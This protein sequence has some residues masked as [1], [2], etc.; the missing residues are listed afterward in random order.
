MTR[1]ESGRLK[2]CSADEGGQG[3]VSHSFTTLFFRYPRTGPDS[4]S[5]YLEWS[6]EPSHLTWSPSEASHQQQ[7]EEDLSDQRQRRTAVEPLTVTVAVAV[8]RINVEHHGGR[9]TLLRYRQGVGS[10]MRHP[11]IS[12]PI[13]TGHR[14]MQED[15][16]GRYR[17]MASVPTLCRAAGR[18]P[19]RRPCR[20]ATAACRCDRGHRPQRPSPAAACKCRL[21]P[22]PCLGCRRS[23]HL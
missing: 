10:P 12:P 19:P 15:I 11:T 23:R 14:W 2:R 7:G 22:N 3:G 16:S 6:N 20:F 1:H 8:G 9:R 5:S 13:T 18:R 21:P 17:T 4:A